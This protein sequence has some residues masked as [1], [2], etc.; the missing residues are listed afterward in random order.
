[1]ALSLN[2]GILPL[3]IL[4]SDRA[5]PR[6]INEGHK[7]TH[8]PL[9]DHLPRPFM[10]CTAVWNSKWVSPRGSLRRLFIEWS[11][12]NPNHPMRFGYSTSVD[13][14][15]SPSEPISRTA[16]NLQGRRFPSILF[17]VSSKTR[18]GLDKP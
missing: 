11:L 14:E 18:P 7:E 1:M 3:F 16:W 8:A 4:S 5:P 12:G 10:N 13:D 9:W 15:S 17:G 6:V 2:H